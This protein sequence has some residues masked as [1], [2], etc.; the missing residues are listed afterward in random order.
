MTMVGSELLEESQTKPFWISCVFPNEDERLPDGSQVVDVVKAMLGPAPLHSDGM[1][2]LAAV[3]M[4]MG[5]NCTKVHKMRSLII[6]F[7]NAVSLMHLPLPHLVMYPDGANDCTYD[8]TSQKWI[9][10]TDTAT[11]LLWEEDVFR[12]L[13]GAQQALLL[14][15]AVKPRRGI[16]L[17]SEKELIS[18]S[19]D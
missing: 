19:D 10:H 1:G 4:G 6:K 15:V 5:L 11:A 8:T 7:E 13:Q 16:L 14:V 2:G 3:P 9:P 12:I 17:A 18:E